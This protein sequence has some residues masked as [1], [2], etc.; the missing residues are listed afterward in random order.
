[1]SKP[2]FTPGPWKTSRD[3]VPPGHVQITVYAE[4]TGER[5][6]TAFEREANARLI[7]AAPALYE[8]LR[9]IVEASYEQ[10][11]TALAMRID[12]ARQNAIAALALVESEGA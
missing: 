9:A 3:A 12:Q 5:V 8:A 6:A 2:N 10:E 1:M 7:A 4:A 11:P